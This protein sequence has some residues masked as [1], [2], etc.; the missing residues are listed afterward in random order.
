MRHGG[1]VY[2]FEPSEA[3]PSKPINADLY[4]DY[5]FEA[6]GFDESEPAESRPAAT[7]SVF[8]MGV[9]YVALLCHGETNGTPDAGSAGVPVRCGRAQDLLATK[10]AASR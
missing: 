2:P 8:F 5:G 3:R 6:P 9:Q 10:D 4:R 7:F 1:T